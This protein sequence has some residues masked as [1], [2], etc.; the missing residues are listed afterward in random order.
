MEIRVQRIQAT[1]ANANLPLGTLP[2]A[3]VSPNPK[4]FS[5]S[6]LRHDAMTGFS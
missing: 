1:P 6:G 3:M 2:P 5:H 4:A